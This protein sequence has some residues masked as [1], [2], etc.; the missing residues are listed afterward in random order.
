MEKPDERSHGD[1]SAES[2]VIY[3]MKCLLTALKSNFLSIV[4]FFA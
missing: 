1:S 2:S 3:L 4:K